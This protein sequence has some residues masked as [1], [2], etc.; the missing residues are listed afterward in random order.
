MSFTE[1]IVLKPGAE[2][3]TTTTQGNTPIGTRAVQG[4]KVFY[5]AHNASIA[6]GAG[7]LIQESV[8]VSGHGG[9]LAVASA[10]AVGA[11][12]VT[13][14]NATTAITANQYAGGTLWA[15]DEAGEGPSY[16]I[17]SH[18]AESTGSG[19]IVI[20]LEDDDTLVEALTTSSQCGLRVA[21]YEDVV[22][23]PTTATGSPIGVTCV[24]VPAD[25]YFWAQTWGLKSVLTN[26]T[27]IV[28]KS[29]VPGASTAGSVDVKP[30]N[31]VDAGG[32][33]PS[34]GVCSRV[35]AT[36]EYSLIDLRI[37]P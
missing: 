16:K 3:L 36:T 10:A 7:L 23:N 28:G 29:V 6:I 4:D 27:L 20:T 13:L 24:D 22:V 30:L 2:K 5:R 34:I 12:T 31:S 9:D 14:T 26:G 17:K 18:P 15:N 1:T 25:A 11:R 21:K 32:Q 35:N 33:E 37:A 8:I 19:S